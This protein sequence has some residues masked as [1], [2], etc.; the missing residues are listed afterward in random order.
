M[1]PQNGAETHRCGPR[2]APH[3]RGPPRRGAEA[4]LLVE[5][6]RFL[7]YFGSL[8]PSFNAFFKP[9]REAGHM[10]KKNLI[11]TFRKVYFFNGFWFVKDD[12]KF[13][14]LFRGDF[15]CFHCCT[16]FCMLK[17]ILTPPRES[18]SLCLTVPVC[19]TVPEELEKTPVCFQ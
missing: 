3:R 9:C 11:H 6:S 15:H 10:S 8:L 2:R 19:T 1:L 12:P 18:L 7:P 5:R 4:G 16:E 17:K 14:L 13:L